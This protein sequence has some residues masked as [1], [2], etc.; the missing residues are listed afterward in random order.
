MS[1][2]RSVRDE[3]L[4]TS[5]V[6]AVAAHET[7]RAAAASLGILPQNLNRYMRR[8][9]VPG[10]RTSLADSAPEARAA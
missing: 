8:L 4:R 2:L 9:G 6:E 7:L 10:P 3:A 1:P 5:I